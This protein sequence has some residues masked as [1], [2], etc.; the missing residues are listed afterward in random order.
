[1]SKW[2]DLVDGET[3]VRVW[4]GPKSSVVAEGTVIG[5]IEAPTLVVRANDGTKT[6]H[7]TDLPVEVQTWRPA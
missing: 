2:T 1:M 4:D 3:R 6:Y 7:S 5:V